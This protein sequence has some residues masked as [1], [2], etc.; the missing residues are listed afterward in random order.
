M[1]RA[2]EAGASDKRRIPGEPFA[3]LDGIS[4][5]LTGVDSHGKWNGGASAL[6]GIET[7]ALGAHKGVFRR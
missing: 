5:Q 3:P 6:Q 4:F 1:Y 2:I 7:G